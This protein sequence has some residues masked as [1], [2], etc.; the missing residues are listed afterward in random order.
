MGDNPLPRHITG[1]GSLEEIFFHGL[2]VPVTDPYIVGAAWRAL[3]S[4]DADLLTTFQDISN[5]HALQFT[6]PTG[7]TSVRIAT[8]AGATEGQVLTALPSW[9][10]RTL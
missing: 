3:D 6:T 9:K 2:D 8:S 10:D 1:E 7:V 5:I 4:R